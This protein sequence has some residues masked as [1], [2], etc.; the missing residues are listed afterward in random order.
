M[1]PFRAYV[2]FL[3]TA[4]VHIIV[5]LTYREVVANV[6]HLRVLVC[7][8]LMQ[9]KYYLVTTLGYGL[10]NCGFKQRSVHSIV[11]TKLANQR[12]S[13]RVFSNVKT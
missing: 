6:Y 2:D 12:E 3:I 9:V 4:S 11:L 10:S 7:Y 13:K 5:S 1:T 8:M